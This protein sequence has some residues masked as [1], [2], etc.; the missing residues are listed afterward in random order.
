MMALMHEDE[1]HVRDQENL[2]LQG[3][4]KRTEA[5]ARQKELAGYEALKQT[6]SKNRRVLQCLAN[7]C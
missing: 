3:E 6:L 5:L 2:F 4:L 1:L 7:N